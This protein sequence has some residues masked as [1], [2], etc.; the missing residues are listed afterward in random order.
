MTIRELQKF[1]ALICYLMG[2]DDAWGFI[3]IEKVNFL[4]GAI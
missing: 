1:K 3:E 4:F 2:R